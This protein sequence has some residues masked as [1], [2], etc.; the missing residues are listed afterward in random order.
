MAQLI[1]RSSRTWHV[2]GE[3]RSMQHIGGGYVKRL[4]DFAPHAD[5]PEH[6]AEF[7]REASSFGSFMPSSYASIFH[8]TFKSPRVRWTVNAML[9]PY[10]RGAW[11]HA[12]SLGNVPGSFHS[13]DLNSAYLWAST[14]GLPVVSSY[15]VTHRLSEVHPGIY[16][17]TL[18][19]NNPL[20]PYPFA[21]ARTVLITGDEIE[22]LNPD[23]ERIHYGITYSDCLP[24]D[25]CT[26]IAQ[27]FSFWKH[28]GRG[29]WGRWASAEKVTCGITASGKEWELGNPILNYIWAALIVS[30]VRMRLWEVSPNAVH[31]F[32]DSVITRDEL[33]TGT[34]LGQWRHVADFP[35]G[36]EIRHAGFYRELGA[37][38]WLKH[39]GQSPS[40]VS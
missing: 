31:F 36:L 38:V 17:V 2:G 4:D 16:V 9:R 6:F 26:R 21:H 25:A 15:R 20:H 30:R 14:L 12:R 19:E 28:I 32:T 34:G 8:D 22:A 11:N 37:D 10:F 33:P 18:R 40:S 23:I 29:Y 39:A 13:Y 24:A 3:L 7:I 5:T 27:D 1:A 35:Q